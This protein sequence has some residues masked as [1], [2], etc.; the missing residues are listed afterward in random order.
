MMSGDVSTR[1]QMSFTVG[2]VSGSDADS[3]TFDLTQEIELLKTAILYADQVKLFSAGSSLLSGFVELRDVPRKQ[4]IELVREYGRGWLTPDQ[5][6]KLDLIVGG[7]RDQ[8]R[9]ATK[10]GRRALEKVVDDG[11]AQLEEMV[12]GEFE[13]YNARGL[14]DATSSG[15][16]ELHSFE[17]TD[18]EG[19]LRLAADEDHLL[20]TAVDD[21]AFEYIEQTFETLEGGTNSAGGVYPLFDAFIGDFVEEAVKEGLIL[22]Y[23]GTIGRSRHAGLAGDVLSQ[24][25]TFEDA[26]VAEVLDVRRGL[27]RPLR[28]FRVAI[29]EY[30]R[31]IESAAW[32]AGFAKEAEALF[33]ESVAPRIAEL[34]QS[35]EENHS[36][37]E[38]ARR[39]GRHGASYGG[40]GAVIGDPSGFPSFTGLALGL[41]VA[42]VQT[43]MDIA[44]RFHSLQG[45]RLYFYHRASERLQGQQ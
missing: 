11:W 23:P 21:V 44:E 3:E 39:M 20:E 18:A 41:G 5:I 1:E 22:P 2:S 26:T 37:A 13:A 4:R 45:N 9:R 7:S 19:I 42:A 17:H 38:F 40:L 33:R 31:E 36:L 16:V 27:E 35:I 32:E 14:A 15:M 43:R 8:R 12:E 34:E 29:A 24:L 30:S 10:R 28:G 6:E 25:P